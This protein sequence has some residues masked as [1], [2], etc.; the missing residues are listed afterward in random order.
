MSLTLINSYDKLFTSKKNNH[1]KNKLSLSKDPRDGLFSFPQK[2]LQSLTGSENL[3]AVQPA[4][5]EIQEPGL[6]FPN[7]RPDGRTVAVIGVGY[8]GL[9]LVQEFGRNHNVIAFD[10]SQ[11]RVEFL[12]Q[13]G[14]VDGLSVKLTSD[15]ASLKHA[16]YFLISVPTLL[17]ADRTIDTSYIQSAIAMVTKYARPGSTVVLESSVAIGTTRKLLSPLVQSHGIKCGMSPE[18]VDPGRT[19]PTAQNIPKIISGL[20]DVA[21]GSLASIYELY[22]STYNTVVPVSRPEVAEMTKL[23]ENC[24][25]MMCIAYANEMADAC[26]PHGIDPFEVCKA[27]SS[28]PFGYATYTPSLG[29]GGHCIPINPYYLLENCDFP[30][31]KACT[32]KMAARPAA[33]AQ[34]LT[35]E[36]K[37]DGRL[38]LGGKTRVLIVGAGF[39]P[40][41]SVISNSPGIDLMKAF[42]AD[43]QMDVA[44]ADPLVVQAQIP[45]V[46]KYNTESEWTEEALGQFDLIVVAIRQHGLD[47]SL[48]KTLNDTK[49]HYCCDSP[50][51]F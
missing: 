7:Y 43:A 9:H 29:V 10:V 8:V 22:S 14:E 11:K 37:L 45:D 13:S 1:L 15:Q 5:Q 47:L 39:K 46:A 26:I 38:N 17:L 28:K 19:F 16:S 12:E 50:L 35:E 2:L 24:Q 4:A 32:E 42:A 40:G 49:V 51:N 18:R 44:F 6:L 27:A 3:G 33:I 20:D 41:Q 30:L 36:M 48:L 23:Y 21:P 34:R 31:L 25:R